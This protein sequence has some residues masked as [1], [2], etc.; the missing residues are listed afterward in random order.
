M[1]AV[2]TAELAVSVF[3]AKV[4]WLLVV[5]TVET[6]ARVAM[7]GWWPT[8]TWRRCWRSETTLTGRRSTACTARVKTCTD[9]AEKI[10]S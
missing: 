2:E 1:C 4:Q 9:V 5:R 6:A 3:V 8:A 10:F 7:C